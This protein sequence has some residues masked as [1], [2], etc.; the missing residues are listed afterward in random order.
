MINHRDLPIEIIQILFP[1]PGED[2]IV[3]LSP[4]DQFEIRDLIMVDLPIFLN[5]HLSLTN[6]GLYSLLSTYIIIVIMVLANNLKKIIY[7]K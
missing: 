1:E 4:L 6:L 5:T 3:Y 7:N 2:E